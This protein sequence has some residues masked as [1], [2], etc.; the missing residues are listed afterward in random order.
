[1]SGAV[2]VRGS[3]YKIL[4]TDNDR[5]DKGVTISPQCRL[6]VMGCRGDKNKKRS[7]KSNSSEYVQ[8]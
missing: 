2:F 5:K 4:V 3:V 6:T 1:M 7:K 8:E